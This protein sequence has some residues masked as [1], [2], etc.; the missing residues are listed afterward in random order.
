MRY[1]QF[2][3]SVPKTYKCFGALVLI[4]A[5]FLLSTEPNAREGFK[6]NQNFASASGPAVYDTLYASMYDSIFVRDER[7]LYEAD[8]ISGIASLGS[9]S[10][11]LDVGSGTGHLCGRL[12]EKGIRC[13]GMD[14]SPAMIAKAK[15][16]YP[17]LEF[18]RGDATLASHSYYNRFDAITCMYF[19]FYE[20]RDKKQFLENC[21]HWLRPGGYLILHKADPAKLDPILPVGNVLIHINPQDYA[22]TKITTT[23]AVFANKDYKSNLT[24][25]EGPHY[26]FVETIVD[27]HSGDTSRRERELLIPRIKDSIELAKSVGFQSEGGEEMADCGY[28]GQYLFIFRK[29]E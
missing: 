1:G 20:M 6:S 28:T 21:Y 4:V 22:E 12:A 18:I 27:R 15:E 3:K 11:V 19:T 17:K 25:K 2:W 10:H 13:S 5:I 14:R 29:Q 24:H 26:S 23:R 7:L 16:E 9:D 8:R